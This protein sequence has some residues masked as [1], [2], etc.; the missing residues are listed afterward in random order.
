[1]D[2]AMT[3]TTVR[4]LSAQ[5]VPTAAELMARAFDGDV[6][7]ALL[8][9]DSDKRRRAYADLVRPRL[10]RALRYG[11]VFCAA[12][13]DS[14]CGLAVWAPPHVRLSSRPPLGLLPAT[15]RA[16]W[17][18]APG[19]PR[20]ARSTLSEPQLSLR[21]RAVRRHAVAEAR[22]VD[23]WHLAGLAVAPEH[24]GRGIARA[25][26]D[27]MLARA[28]IDGTG[29]WLETNYSI[30]VPLYERFGFRTTTHLPGHGAVPQWWLMERRPNPPTGS[31]PR[32][33]EE[34]VHHP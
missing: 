16:V 15:L 11:Q 27:P 23:A 8:I 14:L 24:Q 17:G 2:P 26:R 3:S 25:L 5:E 21:H 18:F 9:P 7:N 20:V 13:A 30:N 32:Q 33:H 19:L 4:R 29:V 6:L 31:A 34:E 1:M 28:D 12:Q 10:V 22:V